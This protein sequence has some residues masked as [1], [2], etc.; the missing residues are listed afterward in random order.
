[1]VQAILDNRKS[2]TRRVMKPQP[3]DGM[4]LAGCSP[5]TGDAHFT[6]VPLD[7][8]HEWAGEHYFAK[9]PYPPGTI[10]WVRE[11]WHNLMDDDGDN[12]V[13]KADGGW[14][15]YLLSWKPSIHM[16]KDAARLFLE[17][18]DVRVERLQE[19]T[20]EDA[21]AEGLACL[22]KDNGITYKYGIPDSD[23]LP[24]NDDHGWH[25]EEW[26]I[27]PRKAFNRLWDSINGKKHPWESNPYVW[28]YEFERVDKP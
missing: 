13:Y 4:Y 23:G 22:T 17:V 19:I 20:E 26:C 14:Y 3:K 11:T 16:P 6:N 12:Y 28:V 9:C 2:L 8:L 7:K 24:G 27:A 25:W 18:T 10:L 1:M 15:V 21:I 5:T